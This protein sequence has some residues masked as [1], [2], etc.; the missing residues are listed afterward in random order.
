VDVILTGMDASMANAKKVG[1]T[2]ENL[3]VIGHAARMKSQADLSSLFAGPE[4]MPVE[5][6]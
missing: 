5:S 4:M 2:P 6:K 1:I 3:M